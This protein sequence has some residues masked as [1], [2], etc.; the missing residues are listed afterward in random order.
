[1]KV[2]HFPL[3]VAIGAF[4]LNSGLSKWSLE[5]QAVESTHA[6][7]VGAVPQF[8]RLRPSVFARLLAG[9]ELAIGTALIV[10]VVPSALVG[11]ALC[12]FG[13]GLMRLYWA[14]PG[15]HQPGDPR[16]TQQGVPLAK[17]SWLI[18]AGLT[19]VADD[20]MSRA[21]R[22]RGRGSRSMRD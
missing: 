2:S 13:G 14:T 3:R 15:M 7:A 5:G 6:M 18:G 17:D 20:L 19:L 12:G 11:L 8:Q 9:T 21:H 1:M 16:P 22:H 4:F 10:P